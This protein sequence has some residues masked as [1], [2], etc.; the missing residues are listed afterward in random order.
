ME[1]YQLTQ[2][3]FGPQGRA[4]SRDVCCG[5]LFSSIWL[6]NVPPER[7]KEEGNLGKSS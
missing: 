7:E 5:H 3:L 6:G 2:K 1:K 4:C